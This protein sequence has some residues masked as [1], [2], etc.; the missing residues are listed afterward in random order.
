MTVLNA[1]S[2][3]VLSSR[4]RGDFAGLSPHTIKKRLFPA[5]AGTL[6]EI[7]GAAN[8]SARATGTVRQELPEAEVALRKLYEAL[9]E[10]SADGQ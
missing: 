6:I 5:V 4:D 8:K 7:M 3:V 9:R 1:N 10:A 2:V